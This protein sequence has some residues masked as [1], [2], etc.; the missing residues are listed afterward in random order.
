MMGYYMRDI[1]SLNE[2]NT[3]VIEQLS[4]IC[5][6]GQKAGL[7]RA[8]IS[9]LEL[10]WQISALSFFNVSNRATFT[11]NFGDELY[12]EEEQIKLRTRVADCVL[13]SV[14]VSD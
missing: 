2:T 1:E 14:R 3:I 7:F 4:R 10:H 9:P 8:D 5:E 13:S 12:S 11:I 6:A